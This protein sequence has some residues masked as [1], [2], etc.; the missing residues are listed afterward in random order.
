MSVISM[1]TLFFKVLSLAKIM[2]W[3]EN[4]LLVKAVLFGVILPVIAGAY[5]EH[6]ITQMTSGD[7]SIEHT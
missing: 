6:E 3:S 7:L 4:I 1:M 2:I 5:F